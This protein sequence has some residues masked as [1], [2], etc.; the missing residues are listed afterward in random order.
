MKEEEIKAQEK[1]R[2]KNRGSKGVGIRKSV[3][4]IVCEYK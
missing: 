1:I 4:E 2:V 3:R